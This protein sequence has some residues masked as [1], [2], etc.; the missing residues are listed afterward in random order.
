MIIPGIATVIIAGAMKLA[1][2]KLPIGQGFREFGYRIRRS[3]SMPTIVWDG[4]ADET[5]RVS[6]F[7]IEPPATSTSMTPAC[8]VAH[9]IRHAG[10][11]DHASAI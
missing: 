10:G 3:N 9:D 11:D 7:D 2:V 5:M 8:V 4:R 1:A 6:L